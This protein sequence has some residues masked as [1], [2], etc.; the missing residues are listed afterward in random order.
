MSEEVKESGEVT[1]CLKASLF[2]KKSAVLP[3]KCGMYARYFDMIYLDM[4]YCIV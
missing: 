3:Y 4:F 2:V 1:G